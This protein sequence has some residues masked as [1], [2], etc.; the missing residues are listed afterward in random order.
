MFITTLGRGVK[1]TG[2]E[3]TGLALADSP[4]ALPFIH[5]RK[6]LISDC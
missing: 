5:P 1:V 2:A 4:T 6:N 3:G